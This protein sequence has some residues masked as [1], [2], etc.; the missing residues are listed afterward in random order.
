MSMTQTWTANPSVILPTDGRVL[1][2]PACAQVDTRVSTAIQG[3]TAGREHV[4]SL[5]GI[6]ARTK[7]AFPGTPA[8]RPPTS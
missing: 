5:V 6:A 7:D 3:K 4:A 8:W 2:M 1:G